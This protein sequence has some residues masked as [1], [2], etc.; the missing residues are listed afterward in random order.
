MHELVSFAKQTWHCL[1]SIRSLGPTRR[2]K[3]PQF[4]LLAIFDKF[5]LSKLLELGRNYTEHRTKQAW[6]SKFSATIQHSQYTCASLTH[7]ATSQTHTHTRTHTRLHTW[8]AFSRDHQ[9]LTTP[10]PAVPLPSIM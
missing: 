9:D 10:S 7:Q 2:L 5:P 4:R 6:V 8:A 3:N 1:L